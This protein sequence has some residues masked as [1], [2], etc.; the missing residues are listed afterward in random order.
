MSEY[1]VRPVY[2]TYF[3]DPDGDL[4]ARGAAQLEHDIADMRLD[5]SFGDDQRVGDHLI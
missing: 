3:D 5:G 2:Q 4:R 1:L